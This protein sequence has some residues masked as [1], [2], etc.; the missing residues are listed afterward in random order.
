MSKIKFT[1][2]KT[3]NE[4]NITK[5]RLSVESKIRYS[6]I[7]DM[8]SNQSKSIN[9]QTLTAILD[10]LNDLAQEKGL[11]RNIDIDDVFV[12]IKK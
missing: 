8:V 7:T 12:Y 5:N 4:I 11:R 10:T 2:G 6:T 1:L 9:I 3:L